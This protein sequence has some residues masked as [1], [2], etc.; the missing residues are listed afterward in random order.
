MRVGLY[1]S[2]QT[3]LAKLIWCHLVVR[4]MRGILHHVPQQEVARQDRVHLAL[5]VLFLYKQRIALSLGQKIVFLFN[6]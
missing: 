2:L 4:V 5:V 3:R 6:K 1:S